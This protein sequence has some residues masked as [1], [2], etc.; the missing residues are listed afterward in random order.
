MNDKNKLKDL[1]KSVN[2]YNEELTSDNKISLVSFSG[3]TKVLLNSIEPRDE[4]FQLI[5]SNLEAKGSTKINDG[6]NFIYNYYLNEKKENISLILFTD[7]LFQLSEESKKIILRNPQI[8]FT[9]FQLGDKKNR[10]LAS[11]TSDKKLMYMRIS[12]KEIKGSLVKAAK[13]FGFPSQY[14]EPQPKI[15]K[16]FQN[17]L[18]EITG[19][20]KKRG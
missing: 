19:Y 9:I 13:E 16:Y 4:R 11:L 20:L 5:I 15:W 6:I 18:L 3:E 12:S 7:G 1:K 8:H 17:N 2:E 14:S 10:E